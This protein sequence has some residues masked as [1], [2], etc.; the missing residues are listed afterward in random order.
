M[1]KRNTID[2]PTKRSSDNN[3]NI[4]NTYYHFL[5]VRNDSKDLIYPLK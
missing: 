1:N 3:A 2:N 4:L 5:S